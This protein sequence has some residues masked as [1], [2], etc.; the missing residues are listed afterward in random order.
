M[1]Q[2]I[3]IDVFNNDERIVINKASEGTAVKDFTKARLLTILN[4]DREISTD[5]DVL[6]LLAGLIAKVERITDEEWD[7]LRQAIPFETFYDAESNVDEV[8]T[9]EEE[10]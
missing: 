4:F 10:V 1:K 3:S 8:P 9:D 6:D 2:K 5:Q 7:H